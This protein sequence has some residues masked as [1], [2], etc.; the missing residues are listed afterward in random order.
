MKVYRNIIWKFI[1]VS[2]DYKMFR[3]LA[4]RG[5]SAFRGAT[6]QV[7]KWNQIQNWILFGK[8]RVTNQ[9]SLK[10]GHPSKNAGAARPGCPL[11]QADVL[12]TRVWCWIWC[13]VTPLHHTIRISGLQTFTFRYIAYFDRA[14]IDGWEIRKVCLATNFT[15]HLLLKNVFYPAQNPFLL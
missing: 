11:F 5:A 2:E 15:R 9:K 12:H 4:T 8:R 1:M 7:T 10:K 6:M 3:V 13:Q 14:D